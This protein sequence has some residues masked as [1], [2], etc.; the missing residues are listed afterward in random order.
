MIKEFQKGLRK[1]FTEFGY[2]ISL[3]VNTVLLTIVYVIGIGLSLII[4]KMR[5]KQFLELELSKE[6]KTYWAE[7]NLKKKSKEKY[8]R[9][10]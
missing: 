6:Q 3:I 8:Y 10:F 7:L 1:G 4:A 2:N 9:Q 5:G